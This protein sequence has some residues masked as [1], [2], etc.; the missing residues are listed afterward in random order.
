MIKQI[1]AITE[2][3]KNFK[4]EVEDYTY[5]ASNIKLERL[6]TYS[7]CKYLKQVK[8]DTVLEKGVKNNKSDIVVTEKKIELKYQLE[9][10]IIDRL[11][12]EI[13][14]VNKLGLPLLE[15]FK[16]KKEEKESKGWAILYKFAYDIFYKKCDYF[17]LVVLNRRK[18]SY[19]QIFPEYKNVCIGYN[20]KKHKPDINTDE[21][22]SIINKFTKLLK[23]TYTYC[24]QWVVPLNK[25]IDGHYL[26][27]DLCFYMYSFNKKRDNE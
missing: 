23:K 27:S 26:K 19:N 2:N 11:D 13:D 10:D 7:I 14:R 5:Y 17:I 15:M 22:N 12:K 24:D 18:D 16:A 1:R 25:K 20:L 4:K 9:I 3:N 8:I 21:L 6:I